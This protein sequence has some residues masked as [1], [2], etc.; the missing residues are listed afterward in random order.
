MVISAQGPQIKFL[1][2]WLDWNLNSKWNPPIHHVHTC[3]GWKVIVQSLQSAKFGRENRLISHFWSNKYNCYMENS[4]SGFIHLISWN[5]LQKIYWIG[6][7]ESTNSMSQEI[8]C[9]TLSHGISLVVTLS[10]D[11]PTPLLCMVHL[12]VKFYCTNKTKSSCHMSHWKKKYFLLF[13]LNQKE[14]FRPSWQERNS[15][16]MKSLLHLYSIAILTF[17][18]L[19][20][21]NIFNTFLQTSN[22]VALC[23]IHRTWILWAEI[24]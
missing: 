2:Q 18:T 14:N 12:I 10:R 23:Y 15:K 8:G 6:V 7:V 21:Q 19:W 13:A 22:S 3:C 5:T 16:S 17:S 24:L 20:G 1:K 4:L 11:C 9:V